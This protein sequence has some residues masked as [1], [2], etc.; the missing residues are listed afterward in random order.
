MN[1]NKNNNEND[2]EPRCRAWYFGGCNIC[3]AKVCLNS[4]DY[5]EG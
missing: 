1:N 4:P 2:Y 5:K 3:E